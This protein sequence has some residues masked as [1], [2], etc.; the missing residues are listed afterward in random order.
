MSV[1]PAIRMEKLGSQWKDF[2]EI[3]C[4]RI[5]PK[6]VEKIRVSLKSDKNK[7]YFIWKQIYIFIIS[8]LFLLRTRNV[9]DKVVEKIQTHF[10]FTFFEN[11]SIYEKMW[12]NSVERG[13]PCAL[14]AG[15][16]KLQIHI[17]SLCNSHCFST[18]T[19]VAR[20]LLN[21]TL[22]IHWLF[23]YIK[24][25]DAYFVSIEDLCAWQECVIFDLLRT[26]TF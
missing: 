15:Y 25:Q 16:L 6:F 19:M 26:H 5:F 24:I 23:L 2:H 21:I 8:R 20:T 17:L 14:H 1:R 22:C 9:S 12:K 11:H 3:W 4:F 18:A 13:R 7:G 10:V